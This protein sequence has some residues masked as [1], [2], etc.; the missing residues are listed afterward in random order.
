MTI[1]AWR[2][3]TDAVLVAVRAGGKAREGAKALYR[4]AVERFSEEWLPQV[5]DAVDL[6]RTWVVVVADHGESWGERCGASAVRDVFDLHGNDLFE[7]SL[8]VPLLLR[9]PGGTTPLRIEGLARTVDLLATLVE[10]L[11]LGEAPA[12]IDGV[13]LAASVREGRPAP[14]A[15]AVSVRNR[16]FVDLPRLPDAPGDLWCGFALTTARHK[17]LWEPAAGSRRA[18]DL[19]ADPGETT[20]VAARDAPLLEG[21]WRRLQEEAGRAVVGPLGGDDLARTTDRLRALGYV[22]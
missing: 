8:R 21:G 11:D 16:D 15:D 19:A 20:D 9:P 17:L 1:A 7:E 4:Y 18:Y 5:L 2:R 13:S 10:L 12:G 22:E 3:L 14:A 6:E